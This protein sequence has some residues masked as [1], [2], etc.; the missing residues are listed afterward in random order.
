MTPFH[1]ERRILSYLEDYD[2]LP[3][4]HRLI[5][6]AIS[7]ICLATIPGQDWAFLSFSETVALN[8]AGVG[9]LTWYPKAIIDTT[10]INTYTVD[11]N[12]KTITF[13][14]IGTIPASVVVRYYRRHPFLTTTG[15][16][17]TSA[18]AF[19][20]AWS[21]T[22][23]AESL[24]LIP[25]E[26][27]ELIV[28]AALDL[29]YENEIEVALNRQ[30]AIERLKEGL[31][32]MRLNYSLQIYPSLRPASP[33]AD[34]LVNHAC[35][36][37]NGERGRARWLNAINTIAG[38][39]A[40]AVK[41]NLVDRAAITLVSNYTDTLPTFKTKVAPIDLWY[42]GMMLYVAMSNL[43]DAKEGQLVA[44]QYQA[45]LAN[46]RELFYGQTVTTGFALG[47]Y[48]EF[49]EYL[50]SIWK[51]YRVDSQLW[52][53]VNEAIADVM[54][55]IDLEDLAVTYSTTATAAT[56]YSMPVGCKR[57]L[58][59]A[60]DGVRIPGKSPTDLHD[61]HYNNAGGANYESDQQSF[62]FQGR[63][64]VF[65]EA[66]SVGT[67]ITVRYYRQH[68]YNADGTVALPVDAM[69]I[70]P[71]CQA[72]IALYDKDFATYKILSA[73]YEA[74]LIDHF[75]NQDNAAPMDQQMFVST[76]SVDRILANY[77]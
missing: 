49:V 25:R 68:V 40:D 39:I 37:A 1:L 4:L 7:R 55:K 70:V 72:Y 60:I 9:T 20:V 35:M 19:D 22:D 57:I 41:L 63:N 74:N 36:K 38:D 14:G 33:T 65:K 47:T 29:L 58:W 30:T 59:V 56:E 77:E 52:T 32:G 73:K 5:N 18:T 16:T 76:Q 23:P 3:L 10:P 61:Q 42:N 48:T 13:A 54:R 71:Y 26:C 51:S 43:G 75:A 53:L 46:F 44:T 21:E 67:A 31:S 8:P 34:Y 69:L 17:E 6:E 27:H 66:P 45:A 2:N 62:Y 24:M 28:Y 50:R 12:N 64:V 11:W 15:L